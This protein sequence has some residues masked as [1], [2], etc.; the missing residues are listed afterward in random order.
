MPDR[1]TASEAESVESWVAEARQK[2]E[3]G[4]FGPQDLDRLVSLHNGTRQ[5]LLYLHAG[6]P[7][8]YSD[9]VAA[10]L[11]EP[12]AGSITEIDPMK[13][14]LPY[15]TVHDAIVD[16]WRVIHFPSQQALYDDREIDVI[17]YEFILEK[18]EGYRD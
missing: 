15:E 5:R 7:S 11:H 1:T 8:I 12:V 16:R 18:R 4:T 14:E 17:G 2:V 6:S 13:P 10:A 3:E 9:V